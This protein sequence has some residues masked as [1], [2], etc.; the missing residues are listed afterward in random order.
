MAE[1]KCSADNFAG[2]ISDV[3]QNEYYGD[4]LEATAQ[5]IEETAKESVKKLKAAP[6]SPRR[7]GK[8]A[9]GWTQTIKKGRA[10]VNATVHGKSGTYQIAHLLEHG[11]AKRGGGR[12]DAIEHIA[13]VERWA[14]DETVQKLTKKLEGMP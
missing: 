13:P 6:P 8:Y 1:I 5:A 12:V 4:V 2:A 7:T 3:L 9:R 14:V 11:H 10:N